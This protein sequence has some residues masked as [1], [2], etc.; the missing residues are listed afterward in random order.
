ME[1]FVPLDDIVQSLDQPW[2]HCGLTFQVFELR[3]VLEIDAIAG[4]Q[5]GMR[6]RYT[7]GRMT[8]YQTILD[9]KVLALIL[10]VSL[11]CGSF[12]LIGPDTRV[13]K[14]LDTAKYKVWAKP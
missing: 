14:Q 7:R 10:A 1:Q 4:R 12:P 11:R 9:R 3:I 6:D 13:R 2:F 5:D 8:P